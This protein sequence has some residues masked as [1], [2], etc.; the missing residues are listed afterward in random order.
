M[1]LKGWDVKNR[2]MSESFQEAMRRYLGIKNEEFLYPTLKPSSNTANEKADKLLYPLKGKR[3]VISFCVSTSGDNRRKDWP[4][5]RFA[6]LSN[7]LI[8]EGYGLVFTG[9][10][11]HTSVIE[12]ILNDISDKTAAL[13]IAGQ[14]NIEELVAVFRKT[15]LFITLD[16]GLKHLR[17]FRLTPPRYTARRA[18]LQNRSAQTFHA[19]ENTVALTGKI[20]KK[21][22]AL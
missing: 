9:I 5:E 1:S 14:T 10:S 4:P 12:Q 3:G 6:G 17:Y 21:T 2:L 11:E 22:I 15:K 7:I 19:R 8:S 16:T 20:A 18:N 13:N